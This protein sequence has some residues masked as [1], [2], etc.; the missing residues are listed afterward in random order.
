MINRPAVVMIFDEKGCL[1]AMDRH[2]NEDLVRAPYATRA[3][4]PNIV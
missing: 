1:L 3:Q 2:Q 4:L